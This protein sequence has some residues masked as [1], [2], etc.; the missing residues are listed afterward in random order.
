MDRAV[1]ALLRGAEA[2]SSG[3]ADA[4][5]GILWAR[6]G[7]RTLLRTRV[8]EP[9]VP[10]EPMVVF[11]GSAH[12]A[13]LTLVGP[14]HRLRFHLDNLEFLQQLGVLDGRSTADAARSSC[15]HRDHLG[16]R[17]TE[18]HVVLPVAVEGERRTGQC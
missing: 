18:P 12:A 5:S 6:M 9:A 16:S 15:G 7:A 14:E 11:V 10:Q 4:A 3:H 2:A 17:M 13:A 1:A 8:H